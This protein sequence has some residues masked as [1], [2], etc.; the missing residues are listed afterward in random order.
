MLYFP[1]KDIL[2]VS[3]CKRKFHN[4]LSRVRDEK[5]TVNLVNNPPDNK[6]IRINKKKKTYHSMT[7]P[8]VRLDRRLFL[9]S[10]MSIL[11]R[12]RKHEAAGHEGQ[13]AYI[14]ELY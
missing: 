13:L 5:I 9:M 1:S 6:K 10:I 7:R 2:L 4:A 11:I 8:A 3:L 12:D 14:L